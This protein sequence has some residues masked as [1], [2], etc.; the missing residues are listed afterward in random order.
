MKT[1]K[2]LTERRKRFVLLAKHCSLNHLFLNMRCC[3]VEVS[4]MAFLVLTFCPKLHNLVVAYCAFLQRVF[5]HKFVLSL[6]T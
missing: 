6:N 4:P 1:T 5:A 2:Q 3:H